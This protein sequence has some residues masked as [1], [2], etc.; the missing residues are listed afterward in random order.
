[1]V[2]IKKLNKHHGAVLLAA[3]ALAPIVL[4]LSHVVVTPFASLGDFLLFC[5]KFMALTGIS[6]F[7]INPL[8]GVRNGPAIRLFGGLDQMYQ[9]HKSSGK[10]AFLIILG[11]P[12]FFGVGGLVS[13]LKFANIWDWSSLLIFTGVLGTV[14]LTMLTAASIYAHITHQR[15]VK[16]HRLFG[17]LI[18]VF[19][20][21]TVL[22]R[23][24]VWE[25]KPLLIYTFGIGILGFSAFIYRSVLGGKLIKRYGYSVEEVNHLEGGVT[26]VALK[27]QNKSMDY[28]P[29]QFA[30]VSFIADG[31]DPEAHPYSFTTSNSGPVIRFAIKALG[32][33]TSALKDLPVGSKAQLEGPYGSFGYAMTPGSEQIWIAGGVGITPFL[34]MARA[35]GNNSGT[36]ISLFYAS[37]RLAD[38]AFLHE[39]LEITR[40]LK[41]F[42]VHIVDAEVS[43]FVTP[44]MIRT[45]CDG[46][47]EFEYLICGPP[48]MMKSLR[49]ALTRDGVAGHRIHTEDFSI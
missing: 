35:L 15:W 3:I 28:Q 39:L 6:L 11:H 30:F 27:P 46:L 38:T 33:D 45:A 44:Q 1:M 34:S 32:D 2:V 10:I 4:W 49:A 12:V 41:N 20:L 17:W 14:G 31:I 26:E 22:A 47:H 16:I 48:T 8:L 23:S 7:L 25:N 18:P 37:Q 36:K 42:R 21:H 29:G 43:G 40:H 24:V 5:G 9:L 19:L 13:G